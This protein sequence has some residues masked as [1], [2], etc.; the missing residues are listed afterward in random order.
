LS[1]KNQLDLMC[2]LPEITQEN[3]FYI[4]IILLAILSG[5]FQTLY[6]DFAHFIYE[7]ATRRLTQKQSRFH[8]SY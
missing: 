2:K 3:M 6:F 1:A 5:S 7:S 8:F 4:H